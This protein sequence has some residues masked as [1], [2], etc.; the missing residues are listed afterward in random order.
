M[1]VIALH[2]ASK[3][4]GWLAAVAVIA[5]LAAA[6][7]GGRSADTSSS[8]TPTTTASGTSSTDF[9]DLASPCGPGD[10]KGATQQGITDTEITIGYGDDAGYQASPGLNHEMADAVKAM[11]NWCN[12]QGGINGRKLVGNYYDAKILDAATAMQE[13][14]SQVFMMVGQG[15]ALDSG[16]EAIRVGC[17]MASVPGYTGS[18]DFAMGPMM[19][20]P[21]PNPTDYNSIEIAGALASAFPDK[22]TKAAVVK[23]TLPSMI[24]ATE[25]VLSTYPT[26]GFEFLGCPQEYQLQGETGWQAIAQRLK[27]CG[28]EM[29]YFSGSP[30]PTFQNF[31]DAS[32]QIGFTPVWWTDANFVTPQFAAWNQN[33][34]ADNVYSRMVFVPL[35]Q[36][37]DNPA[38][39]QYVDIVEGDGGDVS[40]LGAQSTSAFLLWAQGAKA[41]GSNLTSQCVIDNLRK[42]TSWTGGGLHSTTDPGGN[43]P[44][45]C[46][47]VLNLKGTEWV[48]WEPSQLGQFNCDPKYLVKV[49]PPTSSTAALQLNADRI[50]EKNGPAS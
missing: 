15:F 14:C 30:S 44:G 20:Q 3:R 17:N 24:E 49:D 45:D 11:I 2:A 40:L 9:G 21:I 26:Q 16:A 10:A 25:K 46:G 33:G 41:C 36:A 42:V 48:Q 27:D 22:I 35:E 6:C 37:D 28:A 5:I 31:L 13:A 19:V 4:L 1:G 32:N 8:D 47:M 39:K 23:S 38:T 7:A 50:S 12:E 18:S 34:F 43:L 29:V